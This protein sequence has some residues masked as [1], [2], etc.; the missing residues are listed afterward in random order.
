MTNINTVLRDE[1]V[2]MD[3]LKRRKREKGVDY[4]RIIKKF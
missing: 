1:S 3:E 4:L 2:D